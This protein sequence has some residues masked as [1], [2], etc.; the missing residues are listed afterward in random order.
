MIKINEFSERC[1]SSYGFSL[2]L[3]IGL[4]FIAVIT[5]GLTILNSQGIWGLSLLL[6]SLC[7]S[8]IIL[9]PCFSLFFITVITAL[10]HALEKILPLNMRGLINITFTCLSSFLP[11]L[12]CLYKPDVS[13]LEKILLYVVTWATASYHC[14]LLYHKIERKGGK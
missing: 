13:F 12:L 8:L 10:S 14:Y 7:F 1:K 2:F 11:Y 5:Q 6:L 9:F 4:F 3:C